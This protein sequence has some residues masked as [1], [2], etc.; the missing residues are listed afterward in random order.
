MR[1]I[2]TDS[3]HTCALFLFITIGS[4]GKLQVRG[5]KIILDGKINIGGERG[6]SGQEGYS[7]RIAIVYKIQIEQ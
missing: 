4:C 1:P 2:L 3:I 5:E 7:D 6:Q